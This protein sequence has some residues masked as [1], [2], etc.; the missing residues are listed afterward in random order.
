MDSEKEEFAPK[1]AN[2]L[3]FIEK[4]RQNVFDK[5]AFPQ[6]IS[7]PLKTCSGHW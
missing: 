2:S 4:D 1:E 6:N 3:T 5:S 7:I